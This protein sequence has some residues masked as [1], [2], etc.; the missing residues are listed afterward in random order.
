MLHDF[1]LVWTTFL[2]AVEGNNFKNSEESLIDNYFAISSINF[3]FEELTF[4]YFI[5]FY[6]TTEYIC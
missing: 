4:T 5:S 1:S 2:C 3:Y 6:S